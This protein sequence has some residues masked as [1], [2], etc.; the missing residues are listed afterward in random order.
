M[1][2]THTLVLSLTHFFFKKK[3]TFIIQV[4]MFRSKN[5]PHGDTVQLINQLRY[6]QLS[7][8]DV[9]GVVKPH[10]HTHTHTLLQTLTNTHTQTHKSKFPNSV[11]LNIREREE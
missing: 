9:C 2:V 10:T 1:I 7:A 11:S 3:I 5:K 4:K 8:S 6:A